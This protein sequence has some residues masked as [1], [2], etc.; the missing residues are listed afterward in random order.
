MKI[1]G[2]D[3]RGMPSQFCG[4]QDYKCVLV[5]FDET[6]PSACAVLGIGDTE[7]VARHG[8][9]LHS[10]EAANAYFPN[11]AAQLKAH[12]LVYSTRSV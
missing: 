1:L 7:W 6:D 9:V 10:P 12:G 8:Q 11:V 3:S 2:V 5:Q 4:V